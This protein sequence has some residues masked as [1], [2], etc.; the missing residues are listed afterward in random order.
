MK[1]LILKN[2]RLVEFKDGSI[3]FTQHTDSPVVEESEKE[4]LI[5]FLQ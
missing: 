2:Y 4:E 1:T 3:E 5:K